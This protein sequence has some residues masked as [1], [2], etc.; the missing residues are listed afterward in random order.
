[1]VIA[2]PMQVRAITH[3]K[4]KNDHLDA[5]TLAELL[6]ADLLPRVW[7]PDDR[8]RRLRR[9]TSRR[10]QL[11]RARSRLKNEI[12]AVLV[13]NLLGDGRPPATDLFGTR[14]RKW[15]AGL[16]LPVDERDTIDANLRQ[17]DF[18][19]GEL[20]AIDRQLAQET[21]ASEQ[22]R[23]LMTIPGVS[24]VTAMTLLAVIG[25]I[26]RFDSPRRLVGY[27]GLDAKVRQ[28]GSSPARG[29]SIS[30]QGSAD[31]RRVLLEAAWAAITSPGPLRPFYQ[32]IK[33][34]RGAQIAAVAVARKIAVIAWHLLTRGEDY[35]HQRPTMVKRKLRRTELLA[36]APRKK[37]Q[38]PSPDPIYKGS[39]RDIAERELALHAERSYERF[40]ADWQASGKSTTP[41]APNHRSPT[42]T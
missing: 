13:R 7:I 15:L 21:L 41:R 4:V 1:V 32:R 9:L 10:T 24:C 38:R 29:G 6:A 3:A 12:E 8:T 20:A 23:R 19:G 27:L 22:A 37:P 30:K 5:R 25:D 35:A 14:G 17:L 34:R 40:V 18:L 33:A 26:E 31:A 36:G 11:V 2:N 16:Q 39:P 42:R 28:S